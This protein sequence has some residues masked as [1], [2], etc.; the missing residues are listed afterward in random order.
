[1]LAITR[2][3]PEHIKRVVEIAKASFPDPWSEESFLSELTADG[4]FYVAENSG[5]LDGYIIIRNLGEEY[6]ILDVA[7][8][9]A[10]R[11]EGIGEAMLA[12]A[13]NFAFEGW[14]KKVWLEV[15]ESN[16]AALGLYKKYKF[17]EVG[18]RKGY[19]SNP[20]EDAILMER[21]L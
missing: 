15:R 2:A 8:D 17:K 4:A 13:V 6:E 20:A 11:R 12:T 5:S 3:K 9:P 10:A 14:G 16:E 19:Y 7:V 21:Q 1:M 18:R